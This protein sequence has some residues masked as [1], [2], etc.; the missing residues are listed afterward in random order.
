M[1]FKPKPISDVN[2]L[3]NSQK[4]DLYYWELLYKEGKGRMCSKCHLKSPLDSN[5]CAWC[6]PPRRFPPLKVDLK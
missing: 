2:S 5:Y 6:L 4:A 1:K 3:S